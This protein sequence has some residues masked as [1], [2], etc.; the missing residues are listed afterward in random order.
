MEKPIIAVDIDDT[1]ADHAE[2]FV[3]WSNEKYGTN[4]T[5]E[6][7]QDHWSLMWQIEH[8][9]TEARAA[10]FHESG[11]HRH[12]K[13]KLDSKEVLGRLR[14]RYDLVIVT[15]RRQ[16]VI[17]DSML[18]IREEF[19]DVFRE[20]RFVPIWDKG[21]TLTKAAI[22]QELGASY[23]IDDLLRHCSVAAEA[24]LQALLF[25]DYRWNRDEILPANVTRVKDWGEVERY[26]DGR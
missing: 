13:V 2:T 10:A 20:V 24:G 3:Q 25:G 23:L 5:V 15:A 16:A 4:L 12:F 1:L 26:F 19:G 7:Y 17:E 14:E 22:C 11:A 8:D 21:N 6:D 9:E 18:W